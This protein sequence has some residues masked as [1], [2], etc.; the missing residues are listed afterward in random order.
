MLRIIFELIAG[1]MQYMK[2]LDN[3]LKASPSS[4]PI[5]LVPGAPQTYIQTRTRR[6]CRRRGCRRS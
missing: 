3:F 4:T 5:V 6:S 1:E 2:N